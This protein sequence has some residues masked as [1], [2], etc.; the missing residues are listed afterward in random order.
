MA[1]YKI[2]IEKIETITEPSK[3]W[4]RLYDEEVFSQVLQKDPVAKQYDYVET[5]LTKSDPSQI[6]EQVID[7]EIDIKKVIDAFNQ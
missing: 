6:Y 3:E 5:I 1:K 2:T 4:H 7:K